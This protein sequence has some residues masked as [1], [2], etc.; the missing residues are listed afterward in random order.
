MKKAL[1][2]FSALVLAGCAA[3]SD[4]PQMSAAELNECL[5]PNRRVVVEVVGQVV[6][7]P[8]KK[9][10]AKPQETAVGK[11]EAAKP[12]AK[13]EA[14]PAKPEM[15]NFEQSTYVQGNH[16]FDP[17][18]ATLK[19][20]G[21]KELDG[22]IALLKK[23]AVR[24]GAIIIAGHT[25]KLEAESGNKGLSEARAQAVKDYLVSKGLD[26]KL[27]FWEGKEAREPVPVTKFCT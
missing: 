9:P 25:D 18:S 17:G 27:M 12:E 2:S 11:P 6:K 7:P 3:T 10:A 15:A 1:Y 4:T 14:K 23:R 21:Q 22:L 5:Q 20:G 24:I 16:A 8:A 19:E 26:Q 13:P